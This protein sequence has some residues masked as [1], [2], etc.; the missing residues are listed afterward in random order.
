M[1]NFIWEVFASNYI[2]LVKNRAYNQ[3]GLFSKEEQDAAIYTLHKVLDNILLVMYPILP[4]ITHRIYRDMRGKDI[5]SEKFPAPW[6]L[7][8]V[9]FSVQELLSLNGEIWKAKK[10]KGLSLKTEIKETILPQ[11]FKSIEKDL[12]VSHNIKSI[13]WGN[14]LILTI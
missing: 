2:E 8:K 4:F 3:A 14:K 6:K 12:K 10:D 13:K 7:S 5:E 9:P 11:K 1:K